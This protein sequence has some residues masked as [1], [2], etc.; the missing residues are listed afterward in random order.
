MSHFPP[1]PAAGAAPLEDA[2]SHTVA[3]GGKA[4][5]I[6]HA[7]DEGPYALLQR[8][9]AVLAALSIV[10]DG[11]DS[12]LIGFA[13]PVLIKEWGITR[14]AFAP[15]VAAGLIGMG[16]GSAFA[17]VF[18]DRFGRR[19]A[20]I[21]SVLVF[22]AAT[23]AISLAPNVGTIAALRFLAGLGIG[24]AL[25]T[26]TTITAEFTPARFRTF[27]V[28]A[29]IVCVPLGGMLAGLFA[30]QVLPAYGW[31]G[32][33]FAGGVL[34]LLLGIVLFVTLPESPRFLAR[35]E[36]RWPDLVRLL[37]RMGRSVP[38]DAVFTDL[39]EQSAEKHQG[40]A[41]LFRDGRGR[42]TVAIWGAFFM[43]LLAVYAAFSWLPAMLTS[44][45]LS[46]SLAG[47]GLSA[48]N[49]G[50]VIGALLCALAI[51]RYGS[52]WPLLLCCAGGAI[53]AW[54]MLGLGVK[55][56]TGLLILGL[57][58]H[59]LFVNAV[60][61]TMYALCAYVYP[62]SVRATGT[63]SALAFGRIGAI[64][65]AFA[66]AIVITAAGAPGYLLMLGAAMAIVLVA[67]A[68]VGR[69]IPAGMSSYR[70]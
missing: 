34:P 18:A 45:G 49:L 21:G 63:A 2:G 23:C 4:V 40:F 70:R 19:P 69:H 3:Y 16:L 50:G 66:G 20:V 43:C 57:G 62:T 15:V 68:L 51:A 12:Q 41:A 67:L 32:L 27:A 22:G 44:E 30:G 39:R 37:A 14:N 13:I 54:M 31:R 26:S 11:F 10:V 33:F 38:A 8:I 61:S 52:R 65:S 5:D 47:Y 24:G 60:Q 36:G 25:P 46:V 17:G 53:S 6:G 58:L 48:Y 28:T 42:D 55:Q 1:A 56:H 9:A 64:L 29:T 59:G 35:R 7:L